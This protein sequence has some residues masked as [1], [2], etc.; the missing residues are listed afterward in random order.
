M[1][2]PM[3]AESIKTV[4]RANKYIQIYTYEIPKPYHLAGSDLS[5]SQGRGLGW[6][7]NYKRGFAASGT[8]DGIVKPFANLIR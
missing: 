2:A 5:P 7:Q 1:E 4:Y 8:T 6:G 3:T